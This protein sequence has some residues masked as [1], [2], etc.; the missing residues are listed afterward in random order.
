MKFGGHETFPI[1]EGW[2]SRS[3][4]KI[5]KEPEFVTDKYP[6]D[7]LG[8]GRNMYKSI[9]HWLIATEL[10]EGKALRK[11]FPKTLKPTALGSLVFLKDPYFLR[12]ETWWLLHINLVNN[13]DHAATWSWFFNRWHVQRFE[14]GQ[15]LNNLNEYMRM[16]TS[17]VPKKNTLDRDLGCMLASYASK[18]EVHI[19]DPE[20][21]GDC[22]LQDLQLL[23]FHQATGRYEILRHEKKI[24]P[25]IFGYAAV[26]SK[27]KE[28]QESR[29]RANYED[30]LVEWSNNPGGP[31]RCFQMQPEQLS[32]CVNQWD[33]KDIKVQSL[34]KERKILVAGHTP[35]QWAEA[36][37][38]A[39]VKVAI[40][41]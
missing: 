14:K 18:S 40:D 19:E 33:S 17:R 24:T 7:V 12:H 36:V 4:S 13:S 9:R 11:G 39:N 38:S 5:N 1:R 37:Y 28:S 30:S 25:E 41:A 8:V 3:L 32:H 23:R 29:E 6:E 10:V 35:L 20:D 22:P 27:L 34:A 2:L 26:K 16:N 15:C 21:T 31:G